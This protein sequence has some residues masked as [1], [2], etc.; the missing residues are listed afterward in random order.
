MDQQD[1]MRIERKIERREIEKYPSIA[2][3]GRTFN[4][5]AIYIYIY[6]SRKRERYHETSRKRRRKIPS[7]TAPVSAAKKA[8]YRRFL[9]K[10]CGRSSSLILLNSS[11]SAFSLLRKKFTKSKI[12]WHQVEIKQYLFLVESEY[13]RVSRDY[14]WI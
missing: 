3:W 14:W 11:S 4:S 9:M 12:K 7:G 5:R 2:E 8:R 10:Y 6:I 1:R 13:S